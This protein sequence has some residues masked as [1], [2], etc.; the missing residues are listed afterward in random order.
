MW[1][2]RRV[3]QNAGAVTLAAATGVLAMPDAEAAGRKR[4]LRLAHLTDIHVQPEL[5]ADEGLESCLRHVT[6]RKDRPDLILNGGDCVMD[7]FGQDAARTK[8]QWDVWDH[9]WRDFHAVPAHHAIGNHDV[10]GWNKKSSGTTGEEPLYGKRQAMDRLGLGERYY[11]FDRAGWR[12]VVLD[13]TFPH[14]EGGYTARLD[15][16]QFA[17]L[18]ALLADTPAATHVLVLSHIPILCA[19]ALFDGENEKSGDWVIPGAWMH[20]DARRIKDLF[21]R[22]PNVRLALS[23]HIHLRD[24]LDYNGVTYL[25]NGAVC[26]NWW[27]GNYHETPPGYALVDLYDDG[28]FANEYVTYAGAQARLGLPARV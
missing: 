23:G 13:S 17:W 10:W 2:R 25:C 5:R 24:R 11:F 20:I 27:R 1:N 16:T 15:D 7:S 28:S 26:G 14:G 9:V 6:E 4:V 8:T 18:T 19:C 21:F 22:H 3:L 12:F